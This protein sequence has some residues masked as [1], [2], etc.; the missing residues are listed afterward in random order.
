MLETAA[1]YSLKALRVLPAWLRRVGIVAAFAQAGISRKALVSLPSRKAT[2]GLISSPTSSA[3]AFLA[4]RWVSITSWLAAAIS[5]A[6]P[7]LQLEGSDLLGQFE[8][9]RF[10]LSMVATLLPR[11]T[12]FFS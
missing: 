1:W 6:P 2:S 4:I 11:A 12:R 7:R 8:H 5:R 3:E 10:L 9:D